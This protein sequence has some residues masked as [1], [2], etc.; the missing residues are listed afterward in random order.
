M[1]EAIRLADT[2]GARLVLESRP[3]N[4]IALRLYER[5]GFSVHPTARAQL[6]LHRPQPTHGAALRCQAAP[7]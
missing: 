7:G 5:H 6:L 3:D 2:A 1:Q 4:L